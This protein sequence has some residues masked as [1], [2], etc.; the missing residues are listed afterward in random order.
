ME[1]VGFIPLHTQKNIWAMKPGLTYAARADESSR[2]ADL[3][4]VK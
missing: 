3:R 1:D 4:P 2:A